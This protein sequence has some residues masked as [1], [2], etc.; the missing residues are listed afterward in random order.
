MPNNVV[1]CEGLN[2]NVAP[3]LEA[4]ENSEFETYSGTR[5]LN[6]ETYGVWHDDDRLLTIVDWTE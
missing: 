2:E 6:I 5:F 3:A 1:M 4:M